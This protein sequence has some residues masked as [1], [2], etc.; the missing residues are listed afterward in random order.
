MTAETGG[1]DLERLRRL[2]LDDERSRLSDAL[3][4]VDELEQRQ[5]DLPRRLPGLL[6]RAAEG[7][8]AQRLGEA[9]A[10]PVAGALSTAIRN[11]RRALI[12]TLF[13][14][15]GPTIRKA[16]AESMRGLVGDINNA[17]VSSLSLRGLRW[18]LESW[19]SGVPYSQI[20]LKH[21]LNYRIDHVFLIERESGLLLHHAHLDDL[22]SLDG[23]AIAGMLTAIGEFV[24][25]SV[26][27]DGEGTL[28]SARVGEYLL[29]LSAGPRATLACFVRGVPPARFHDVLAEIIE[30]LHDG[31]HDPEGSLE[32]LDHQRDA[33]H[34]VAIAQRI[35]QPP[36]PHRATSL[37]PLIL[38]TLAI[39]AALLWYALRIER[40]QG[41]VG[42]LTAALVAQPGFVLVGV[43]STPWSQL[44]IHGLHDPDAAA[45]APLLA[46]ADLGDV[47]P[48]LLIDG[49]LS[50]DDAVT[51][52]RAKRVLQPPAGVTL[53]VD[54]GVLKLQGRADSEW[55]SRATNNAALIAGVTAT[56]ID[57][58]RSRGDLE[59]LAA[60][61][62][63]QRI[64][65]GDDTTPRYDPK[66]DL[67]RLASSVLDAITLSRELGVGLTLRVLGDNDRPGSDAINVRVRE[68][69]RDWLAA[70]LVERGV[71]EGMLDRSGLGITNER[72]ARVQ[73]DITE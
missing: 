28:D 71:P 53:G 54:K 63:S 15:V 47:Q 51:L 24:R 46:A 61:I 12:D 66:A 26:D 29:E 49:Y 45:L 60:G 3:A 52:T 48:Q 6:S 62:T 56:D 16:I 9:L 20:V 11:N 23:D 22:P 1:S 33:L 65:F 30:E 58:Q 27:R 37:V 32:L 70:A 31:D 72:G 2:L 14:V 73:M 10:E 40:W 35:G 7:E 42:R 69:R 21:T 55:I 50:S 4:R 57:V 34:P 39:L 59:R 41:E 38:I 67:D 64:L 44:R 13:P 19:R 5:R 25:D 43:E 36:M 18:R 8:G 68:R 17:L